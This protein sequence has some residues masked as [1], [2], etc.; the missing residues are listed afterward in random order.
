MI[1][2]DTNVLVRFLVADDERQFEKARRLIRREAN[3]GDPALISQLVLL[4]C[5]WVLRSRYGL[6]KDDILAAFSGLL[7]SPE[8]RV[9][10]EASVEEALYVWKESNAE[11]ADC[12]IG[13]RYRALG[14]GSVV[15]FDAKA[16]KVPG[17]RLA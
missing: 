12:L 5:E 14:C 16:A 7:E 4:E 11:F 13:A 1:G 10:D 9:E 6:A 17:F 15:S 2:P 8:I 3:I